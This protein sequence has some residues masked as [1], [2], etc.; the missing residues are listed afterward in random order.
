M[1]RNKSP[2]MFFENAIIQEIIKPKLTRLL[3]IGVTSKSDLITQFEAEYGT[4]PSTPMMNTWLMGSGYISL[5]ENKPTISLDNQIGFG[6]DHK[7]DGDTHADEGLVFDSERRQRP[8][9]GTPATRG[10]APLTTI[11][12]MGG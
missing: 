8:T 7:P 10:A 4:R 12:S 2:Y 11:P 1:P 9:R 5:F 3:N 6:G